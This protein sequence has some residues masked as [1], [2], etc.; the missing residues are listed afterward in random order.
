MVK[1]KKVV[2]KQVPRNIPV[3]VGELRLI[4]LRKYDSC[5]CF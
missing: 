5:G 3:P 1:E 2:K 4:N